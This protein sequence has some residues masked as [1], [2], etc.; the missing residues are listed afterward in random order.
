MN[1]PV[2]MV[3]GIAILFFGFDQGVMSGVNES[4]DYLRLMGTASGLNGKGSSRDSAAVGSLWFQQ[5]NHDRYQ[6]SRWTPSLS[7]TATL[8]TSRH[9][10]W[11]T[12][13]IAQ[14]GTTTKGLPFFFERPIRSAG[15]VTPRD[16]GRYGGPFHRSAVDDPNLL[17]YWDIRYRRNSL[18]TTALFTFKEP[19]APD[20]PDAR[21]LELFKYV[22][23]LAELQALG[24]SS[25]YP[26]VAYPH[27]RPL[28][29]D[30]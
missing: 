7:I 3:A 11:H 12:S 6:V 26:P 20:N 13:S 23:R 30:G 29:I 2:Q 22:W 8:K 17:L 10:L 16:T 25:F 14:S 15:R 4:K 28:D 19:A 27:E 21:S 18:N 5:T 9:L 24:L 1:W